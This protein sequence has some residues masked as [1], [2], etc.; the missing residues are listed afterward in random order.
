M[1]ENLNLNQT[2]FLSFRYPIH[3]YSHIPFLSWPM[4]AFGKYTFPKRI[5]LRKYFA[6]GG[7]D[8]F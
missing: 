6:Y 2:D 8:L 4:V 1:G 7:Q 5:S 3:T